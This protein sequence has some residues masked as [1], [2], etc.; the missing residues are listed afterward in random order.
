MRRAFQIAGARTVI[1]SLWAV[2][3]AATRSWM[4]EL[5]RARLI[6]K[7]DTADAVRDA[8]LYVLRER[9]AQARST[10]PFY[11]AGFVASGYWN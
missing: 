11:W 9:R 5:Y 8:S 7:L 6:K 4:T 3:D 10:L 1:M 2:D